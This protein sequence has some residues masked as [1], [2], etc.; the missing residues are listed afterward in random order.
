MNF[1]N[2]SIPVV[3]RIEAMEIMTMA[4]PGAHSSHSRL[5]QTPIA[6]PVTFFAASLARNTAM[7][8]TLPGSIQ[9][10]VET[11]LK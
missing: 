10:R 4:P 5:P 3:K 8:A 7:S 1:R 9:L 11:K 6:W 2:E